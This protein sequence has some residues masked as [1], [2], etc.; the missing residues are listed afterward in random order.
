MHKLAFFEQISVKI[1]NLM[2]KFDYLLINNH[3]NDRLFEADIFR[4]FTAK[5]TSKI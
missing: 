3:N 1:Y 2:L 5:N 4:F